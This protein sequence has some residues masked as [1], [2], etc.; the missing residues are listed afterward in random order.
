LAGAGGG[1]L[2]TSSS[3]PLA[4][5]EEGSYGRLVFNCGAWTL[6]VYLFLAGVYEMASSYNAGTIYFLY[7]SIALLVAGFVASLVSAIQGK[8]KKTLAAK[9]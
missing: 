1:D 2:S 9:E 8:T 3:M 7:V 6:I 5:L 4:H